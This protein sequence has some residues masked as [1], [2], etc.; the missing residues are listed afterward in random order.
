[1]IR[2]SQSRTVG[3]SERHSPSNV[4]FTKVETAM[5]TIPRK[6]TLG[7]LI[8][9]GVALSGCATF[10]GAGS[11]RLNGR[12]MY[13]GY[14]CRHISAHGC[15]YRG[16]YGDGLGYLGSYAPHERSGLHYGL[17]GHVGP[18][19]A[20]PHSPLLPGPFGYGHGLGR[21]SSAYGHANRGFGAHGHAG[22]D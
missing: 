21:H 18:F 13:G 22:R 2:R 12:G 10:G 8:V 7:V 1:M 19:L 3:L 17:P 6:R 9:L 11:A 14:A 5:Q 4:Q 15:T 20:A 16:A